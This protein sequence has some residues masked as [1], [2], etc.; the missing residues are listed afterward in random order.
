MSKLNKNFILYILLIFSV[1]IS[2]IIW[3]YLH[4]PYSGAEIIGQYSL[5]NYHPFNDVIKYSIFILLP[6]ITLFCWKLFVRKKKLYFLYEISNFKNNYI[7]NNYIIS[8]FLLILF[9]LILLEFFSLTFPVNEL[10]IYHSGQRLS[11][12]IKYNL[13]GSLWSSSYIIVGLIYEILGSKFI[14]DIFDIQSIGSYRFLDLFYIL[15][16]KIIF[17]LIL[18]EISKVLSI[19]NKSKI[20]FIILN[21]FLFQKL[22]DY[23]LVTYDAISF[24]DL[25][26]LISLY[27]FINL[28]NKNKNTLP[29]LMLLGILFVVS[30]FWSIDRAIV[31]SIL[32]IFILIFLFYSKN[33]K[34]CGIIFLSIISS[35]IVFMFVF[36][37]EFKYFISDT[38]L[39]LSEINAIHGIIHPIPFSDDPNASRATKT[40]VFILFTLLISI[41]LIFKNNSKY[42]SNLKIIF[43]L[44][45]LIS[46]SSYIYAIGR[47]DGGHINQAFGY[48]CIFLSVFFSYMILARLNIYLKKGLNSFE[49]IFVIVSLAIFLLSLN[50]NISN[51]YN[52]KSR[53][54]EYVKIDDLEY[55]NDLDKQFVLEAREITRDEKCIQL[56]TNDVA[57]LYLLKKPSC[58]KFYFSWSIGSLKNQKLFIDDLKNVNLVI[59]NGSTDY[60]DIP[61]ETKYPIIKAYIEEE[62]KKVI[63]TSSREIRVK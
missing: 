5:N 23:N 12:V 49:N 62:F 16:I 6:S 44:L 48:P 43:I 42:S 39:I 18:F 50:F 25:P 36:G 7:Q 11:S 37:N 27:L 34:S 2:T 19:S 35:L 24:R 52:F 21:L 61:L 1:L 56:F 55:L 30:F 28:I 32:L 26:I 10:D 15:N 8:F 13:D 31:N 29:N 45:S 14:W 63:N 51:V 53:L 54:S 20:I 59:T 46:V 17:I 41:N 33:Y 9:I 47:S 58:S 60:W 3:E 4:I 40:I 22:I 57:L 38:I